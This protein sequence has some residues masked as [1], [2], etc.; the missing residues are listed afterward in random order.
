M[1]RQ[2]RQQ[3]MCVKFGLCLWSETGETP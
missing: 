3:E 1:K 2:I